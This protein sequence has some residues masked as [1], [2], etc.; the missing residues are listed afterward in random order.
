[1]YLKCFIRIF[2]HKLRRC[3]G[4]KYPAE[5]TS[6]HPELIHLIDNYA[7]VFDEPPGLPP[8]RGIEHQITLKEASLPKHQHPYRV[9]HSQKNEIE[10][11]VQELLSSGLIQP[12]NSPFASPVLLVRK[13]DSTWRMCVDYMYLNNLTIKHDFPIPIIDELL[14]E[15]NG[16]QYFSKIDL[17]SGYF[18]ILMRLEDRHLTAFNTHHGQFEFLVMPFG[19]C[20]A[21]AT[22]QSLMNQVFQQQLRKTVLVFFDDILVYRKSWC[23]HLQHLEEVLQVLRNNKLYAK[24]GKCQFGQEQ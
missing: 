18:Q 2:H 17:R 1:L 19:L 7:D 12:S 8:V 24:K 16:A 3:F 6:P 10:K 21:P 14:D 23:E 15:L 9:S 5:K 4:L 22:F 13:K 11:I 20:N